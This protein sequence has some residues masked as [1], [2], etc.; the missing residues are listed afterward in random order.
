V[1]REK[2]QQRN[3]AY[4]LLR[5][6]TLISNVGLKEMKTTLICIALVCLTCLTSGCTSGAVRALRHVESTYTLWHG[7]WKST[8]YRAV[9][10]TVATRLPDIIAIGQEVEVPVAISCSPFSIWRPGKTFVGRC[11][12]ILSSQGLAAAAHS[13]T[14]AVQPEDI[15]V[16]QLTQ[17]E[18]KY[19]LVE[20]YLIQFNTNMTEATG[21]WVSNDGDRGTFSLKKEGVQQ[22]ESTVP[23]KAAPSSSSTVR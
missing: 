14:N 11:R 19:D 2:T 10:G 4:F 18:G 6:K 23:V 3:R 21:F 20:K 1:S 7:P 8:E 9:H 16:L 12:G 22:A 17:F 15:T 13:P 5:A